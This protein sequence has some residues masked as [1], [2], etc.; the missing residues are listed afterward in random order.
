[1]HAE[2]S[3]A[4]ILYFLV[5]LYRIDKLVLYALVVTRD[6]TRGLYDQQQ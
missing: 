4:A 5:A 6:S 3:P 2:D 1:M